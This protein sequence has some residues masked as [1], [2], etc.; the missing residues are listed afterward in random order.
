MSYIKKIIDVN[1][2]IS[3]T[4]WTL[5]YNNDEDYIAIG[6]LKKLGI[7]DEQIKAINW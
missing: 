1:K 6:R 5:Y 4:K 2:N 7:R 3:D